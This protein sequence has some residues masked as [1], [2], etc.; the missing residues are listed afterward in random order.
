RQFR[1]HMLNWIARND[2]IVGLGSDP[3]A[4]W[5][6]Y[7]AA[8]EEPTKSLAAQFAWNVVNGPAAFSGPVLYPAAGSLIANIIAE[9]EAATEPVDSVELAA[10]IV[11]GTELH[12]VLRASADERLA[13]LSATPETDAGETEPGEMVSATHN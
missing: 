10:R 6:R 1:L 11:D 13:L 5:E 2:A 8:T 4:I 7:F 3:E 12:D 9:A